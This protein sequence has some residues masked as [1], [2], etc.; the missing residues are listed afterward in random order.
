[1][2]KVIIDVKSLKLVAKDMKNK[3]LVRHKR[4]SYRIDIIYNTNCEVTVN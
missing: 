3:K 2:Q 1:M 4:V